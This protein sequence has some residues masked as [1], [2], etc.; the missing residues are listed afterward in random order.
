MAA[1]DWKPMARTRHWRKGGDREARGGPEAGR[2]ERQ[3]GIG[4]AK[5]MFG[6]ECDGGNGEERERGDAN[7]EGQLRWNCREPRRMHHEGMEKPH[8]VGEESDVSKGIRVAAVEM[9]RH[10]RHG[11]DGGGRKGNG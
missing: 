9:R 1:L 2:L 8:R 3:H 7:V 11:G 6:S 4:A 5:R 10:K